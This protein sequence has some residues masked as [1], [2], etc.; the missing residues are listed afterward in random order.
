MIMMM[1]M[2]IDESAV[3]ELTP[4]VNYYPKVVCRKQ[5]NSNFRGGGNGFIENS[6]QQPAE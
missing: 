3:T 5:R 1:M 4:T 2:M 6:F